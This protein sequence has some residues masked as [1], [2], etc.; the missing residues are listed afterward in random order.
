MKCGVS[1]KWDLKKIFF[2][3][4]SSKVLLLYMP[5]YMY[6]YAYIYVY[7]YIYVDI[8][9]PTTWMNFEKTVLSERSQSE[10]TRAG[11]ELSI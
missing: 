6:I 11:H 2:S 3:I 8:Y 10:K 4:K 7:I 1:G 5:I 9:F